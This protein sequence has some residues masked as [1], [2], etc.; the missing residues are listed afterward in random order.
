[1][2][3]WGF[4]ERLLPRAVPFHHQHGMCPALFAI[5]GLQI[6]PSIF[7]QR[8]LPQLLVL[9][10]SARCRA[11][12]TLPRTPRRQRKPGVTR[13]LDYSS[14]HPPLHAP[15]SDTAD[16][17]LTETHLPSSLSLSQVGGDS[18]IHGLSPAIIRGHPRPL[19]RLLTWVNIDI[20]G[21]FCLPNLSKA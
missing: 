13:Q 21:A 7:K 1:M 11:S 15:T 20:R 8:E 10:M 6:Q 2:D 5:N 17:V 19:L 4:Q 16:Q 3:C 14:E 12:P 18:P 9:A